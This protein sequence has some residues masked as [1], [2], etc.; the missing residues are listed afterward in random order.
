M[1]PI[2][3]SKFF[4]S[5]VPTLCL[6]MMS[7]FLSKEA[8]RVFCFYFQRT[9]ANLSFELFLQIN[10]LEDENDNAG[11][12]KVGAMLFARKHFDPTGKTHCPH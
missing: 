2:R 9:S 12:K 7:V 4:C 10:H 5:S 6:G 1:G 11:N 3:V 8:K